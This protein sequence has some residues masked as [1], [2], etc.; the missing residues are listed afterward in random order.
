MYGVI[1]LMYCTG[2]QD[3]NVQS[4]E[5]YP[6]YEKAEQRTR[7]IVEEFIDDFGED[8]IEYGTADYPV[9]VMEN[10]GEVISYVFIEKVSDTA[11]TEMQ[12]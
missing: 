3:L 8:F 11:K 9:T 2:S 12:S 4:L 6:T 7:E 5:L 10:G 1:Y